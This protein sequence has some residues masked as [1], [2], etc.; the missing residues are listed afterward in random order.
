MLQISLIIF[1]IAFLCLIFHE[2]YILHYLGYYSNVKLSS[3]FVMF[4][5]QLYHNCI[6]GKCRNWNVMFF[7]TIGIGG[8]TK[9]QLI[10]DETY[11]KCHYAQFPYWKIDI[12]KLQSS[13]SG[14]GNA[15]FPVPFLLEG[16]YFALILHE[17]MQVNLMTINTTS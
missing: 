6:N 16:L 10:G 13:Y 14:A 7:L 2:Y 4:R 15:L 5:F 8:S 3:S 11:F 1:C 9:Y 12:L 17:T